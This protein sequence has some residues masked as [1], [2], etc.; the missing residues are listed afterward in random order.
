MSLMLVEDPISDIE[1]GA[2]A[3]RFLFV[4]SSAVIVGSI[5]GQLVVQPYS[6]SEIVYAGLLDRN[7]VFRFIGFFGIIVAFT[8]MMA[9]YAARPALIIMTALV[10]LTYI[11]VL[12]LVPLDEIIIWLYANRAN[13]TWEYV[14]RL[15]V[16]GAAISYLS[17]E[18]LGAATSIHRLRS[19]NLLLLPAPGT[20]VELLK[21][22]LGIHDST[23]WIASRFKKILSMLLFM[24]S[25]VLIA[26][27]M[28]ITL[29]IF[30]TR[31]LWY[32]NGDIAFLC[33][34]D[35]PQ[36]GCLSALAWLIVMPVVLCGICLVVALAARSTARRLCRISLEGVREKD[37]RSPVLFL[38][39][40]SDDQVKLRRPK[41]S[42][43]RKL[44]LLGEPRPLLDHVL[45]EEGLQR[46]PVVAIGVPGTRPPF[47][48]ARTYV[49][50]SVWQEV[51]AKLARDSQ[52]IVIA[53]DDTV[54]VRWEMEHIVVNG[55]VGKTLCLLPPR[56]AEARV[57]AIMVTTFLTTLKR[58]DHLTT[59]MVRD[60]IH[61]FD[62][63]CIGWH[64]RDDDTLCILT[65]SSSSEAAYRSAVRKFL[66]R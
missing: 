16:I 42:V 51:V 10:F 14:F 32:K 62:G 8:L 3:W 38:R 57:A 17:L 18:I 37:R 53:L 49:S 29:K 46:G 63:R 35:G 33:R 58:F 64:V 36:A 26:L 44:M 43:W 28:Y 22:S 4:T 56:L 6:G 27:F 31:I 19:D 40:F 65:A 9:L 23:K 34:L 30:L 45:L 13:V 5:I 60:I 21:Q 54:G 2:D 55:Y 12:V 66:R 39:P 61:G 1:H 11:M 25:H 24:I 59:P 48:V 20:R 47:G 41:R 52:V 7:T 50:D 15:A